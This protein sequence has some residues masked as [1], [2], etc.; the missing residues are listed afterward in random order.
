MF[1]NLQLFNIH[2]FKFSTHTDNVLCVILKI[3][4]LYTL[5]GFGKDRLNVHIGEIAVKMFFPIFSFF[6][7]LSYSEVLCRESKQQGMEQQSEGSYSPLACHMLVEYH[8]SVSSCRCQTSCVSEGTS[9]SLGPGLAIIISFFSLLCDVYLAS[10]KFLVF[11][12]LSS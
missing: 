9:P 6:F 4:D 10:L 1:W 12:S 3:C 8:P 5:L 2:V 7:F 11:L